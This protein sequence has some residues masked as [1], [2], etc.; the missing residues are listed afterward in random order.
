[1]WWRAKIFLL[2]APYWS[3][4]EIIGHNSIKTMH[5]K[6][7]KVLFLWVRWWMWSLLKGI[8]Q[9][10]TRSRKLSCSVVV[11]M[12][13]QKWSRN[14]FV[15]LVKIFS[16]LAAGGFC[17]IEFYEHILVF[18]WDVACFIEGMYWNGY[19]VGSPQRP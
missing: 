10:N 13:F 14:S 15:V 19:V 5:A 8:E 2:F 16:N 17:L 9:W 4:W 3:F 1:M 18:F 12:W 11:Y 7:F 6:N